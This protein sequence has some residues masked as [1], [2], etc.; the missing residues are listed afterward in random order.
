MLQ[1]RLFNCGQI[2]QIGDDCDGAMTHDDYQIWRRNLDALKEMMLAFG[3]IWGIAGMFSFFFS[4]SV[5]ILARSDSVAEWR[6]KL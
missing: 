4:C 1:I 2:G 5:L 6:K 3:R